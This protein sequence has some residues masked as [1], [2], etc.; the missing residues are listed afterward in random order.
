MLAWVGINQPMKM[1][2]TSRGVDKKLH[3]NNKL[4]L[5]VTG[6]IINLKL[7]LKGCVKENRHLVVIFLIYVP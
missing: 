5:K 1:R 3:V 2:E 4:F 6:V 7:L